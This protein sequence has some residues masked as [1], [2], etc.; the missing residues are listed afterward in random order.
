MNKEEILKKLR[1]TYRKLKDKNDIITFRIK[2]D[3]V[4]NIFNTND[5]VEYYNYDNKILDIFK[6]KFELITD[7]DKFYDLEKS[8]KNILGV[9]LSTEE[10]LRFFKNNINYME[11]S[12]V[13]YDSKVTYDKKIILTDIYFDNIN[14]SYNLEIGY[15][16]LN[17]KEF[18]LILDIF[19][20]KNKKSGDKICKK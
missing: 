12:K 15:E 9:V 8:E 3:I 5:L 4:S 2:I 1:K 10:Q 6:K 20:L 16:T 11:T 7:I 18:E 14:I 13:I 19:D 17:S